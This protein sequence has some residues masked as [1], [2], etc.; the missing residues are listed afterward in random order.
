MHIAI[1]LMTTLIT[2]PL[3]LVFYEPLAYGPRPVRSRT[4][5]LTDVIKEYTGILAFE[6]VDSI[7]V[8]IENIYHR[9]TYLRVYII[10][11][12]TN[13]VPYEHGPIKCLPS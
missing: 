10:Y 6:H 4:Q 1:E 3:D 8:A 9:Y 7:S 13:G 11:G 5:K 2:L 12:V